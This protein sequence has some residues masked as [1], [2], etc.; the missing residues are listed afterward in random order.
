MVKRGPRVL[1]WLVL[2]VLA[3]LLAA[4]SGNPKAAPSSSAPPAASSGTSS[5]S[6]PSP[7]PIASP[8]SWTIE[9]V[10][11]RGAT[12]TTTVAIAPVISG[13]ALAAYTTLYGDPCSLDR[14]TDAIV[15]FQI[16]TTSTNAGFFTASGDQ[17]LKIVNAS[18]GVAPDGSDS[19]KGAARYSVQ[20]RACCGRGTEDRRKLVKW[21]DMLQSRPAWRNDH[22]WQR[23]SDKGPGGDAEGLLRPETLVRTN[24][25]GR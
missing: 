16:T 4:C 24:S 8:R 17:E 20:R 21:A 19:P 10:D 12:W 13:K 5:T 14:T 7:P 11:S 3:V 23:L 22:P 15:P 6:S 1:C 9:S 2:A 18:L 25:S